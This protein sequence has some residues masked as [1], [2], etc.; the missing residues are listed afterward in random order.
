MGIAVGAFKSPAFI[1][2]RFV[3][4]VDSA[5]LT[6]SPKSNGALG[7][8]E[9]LHR[10]SL[11]IGLHFLPGGNPAK[12]IGRNRKGDDR[13]G[14]IRILNLEAALRWGKCDRQDG[15]SFCGLLDETCYRSSYFFC[16][17]SIP[18]VVAGEPDE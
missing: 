7:W 3:G 15:V 14:V 10:Y 12:E 16:S 11:E 5:L 17:Q 2:P 6:T 18:P 4:G 1:L 13:V 9:T 8:I